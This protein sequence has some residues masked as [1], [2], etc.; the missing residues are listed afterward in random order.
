A[1]SEGGYI[2]VVER[3]LKAGADVNAAAAAEY[4]GRTALQ[5]A[6]EGGHIQVIE[7]LLE[8]R[9]RKGN[10]ITAN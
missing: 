6:S 9:A 1:A 3:L 4:G 5:A 8:A 2:Q 7:R 10:L